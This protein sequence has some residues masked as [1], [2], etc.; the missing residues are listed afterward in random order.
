MKTKG[1]TI[2][3]TGGATGIGFALAEMFVKAENKVIVCG[4]RQDRLEEAKRK[5]PQIRTIKCDISKES[6]QR[7]LLEWIN[8]NCKD[9]NILI[10]NAGVMRMID[11]KKGD[12]DKNDEIDINLK[13]PINL[14]RLF[15]P[16][17]M[18][19]KEAAI[20]NVSSGL[21]FAPLAITPI[22]CATKAGLHSFTL[23]L[24]HQL[25]NTPIKV[26]EVI[27]PRVDTEL[28]IGDRGGREIKEEEKGIHVSQ[29]AETI[30][31]GIENNSHEISVGMS[32]GLKTSSRE[33]L[34]E[35]FNRM[36][37]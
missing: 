6:E 8:K 3:I 7:E 34:D 25:K 23:S 31:K 32:D 15:I 24:R 36:N 5:L 37:Q 9:L 30:M 1:N 2:L 17:L 27:P 35:A 29:M 28:G 11:L 26:F 12:I 18:R 16:H 21:A 20:V 22:Y 10:N 14:S 33:Q 19:K 4:R 13:A